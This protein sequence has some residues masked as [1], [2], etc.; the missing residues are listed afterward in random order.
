MQSACRWC[1][2]AVL[3]PA[4][5]L[6]VMVGTVGACVGVESDVGARS[7][8]ALDDAGLADVEIENVRYRDVDLEGP[9]SARD[10]AVALV[11]DLDASRVVGY[12]ILAIDGAATAPTGAS[13]STEPSIQLAGALRDGRITLDGSVPGEELVATIRAAAVEAAGVENFED[14]MVVASGD[15]PGAGVEMGRALGV[16]VTEM[17]ER[18]AGA[19]FQLVDG[20]LTVR[21][22]AKSPADASAFE[23]TMAG[24]EALTAVD[25]ELEA[26]TE[27]PPVAAVDVRGRVNGDVIILQG[28]VTGAA[29]RRRLVDAAAAVFGTVTDEIE[30][31]EAEPTDD[32]DR[33]I[34]DLLTLLPAMRGAL[35]EADFGLAGGD[36]E[37]TGVAAGLEEWLALEATL[38]ALGREVAYDVD[39]GPARAVAAAAVETGIAEVLASRTITFETNS[40]TI[41]PNGLAVV[42]EIFG[43]LE[44]AMAAQSDLQVS[45]SGHTDSTGDATYNQQLSERRAEAVLDRLVESGIPA[46]NLTASGFGETQPAA[47]NGTSEG[48]ATN[49]RIEFAIQ[50]G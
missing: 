46:A 25:V 40:S 4:L 41:T 39:D 47:D 16:I 44:R 12:T 32:T 38:T 1:R 23:V 26:A 48:R 45:I 7:R 42:E 19:D 11:E 34:G 30:V 20:A 49:R 35:A 33:A 27:D 31:V 29:E 24:L 6:V 9:E 10:R 21:G 22:T 36:L 13:D 14:R 5:A 28:S 15:Q 43:L 17:T 8:A 50:E 37:L 18:L 2:P 3:W